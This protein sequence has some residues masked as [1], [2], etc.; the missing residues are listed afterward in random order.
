MTRS[1]ILAALAVGALTACSGLENTRARIAANNDFIYNA[2]VSEYRRQT[3]MECRALL[4]PYSQR[5]SY[6]LEAHKH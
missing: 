6:C 2:E 4:S 3:V 1:I 5:Y